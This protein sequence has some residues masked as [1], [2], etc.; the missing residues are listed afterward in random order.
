MKTI[1]LHL[2]LLVLLIL[3]ACQSTPESKAVKFPLNTLVASSHFKHIIVEQ[4]PLHTARLHVYI[5][6]DGRPYRNRFLIA[7]DPSPQNPL[8]LNLMRQDNNSSLYL[9]R[10]CYFSKSLV[11]MQDALCSSNYWT[12]ARYSEDI[13]NS[14]IAALREYLSAHPHNGISLIGHSGGG[15]LAVLMAARM[16]EVDQVVT[17]AGNLD[18][19]AWVG[20]HHYTRLKHSLNPVDLNLIHTKQLHFGGDKD[21]NIPPDLSTAWLRSMGQKMHIIKDADH[22]C[23]WQLHWKNLLVHINQQ[24]TP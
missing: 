5:E 9:G 15:T 23:C 24:M 14:M 2:T 22:N 19:T 10:P 20:L 11:A 8:M 17:L 3:S 21:D 18:I 12:S 16:P 6:G 13:V 7:K 1:K 4:H